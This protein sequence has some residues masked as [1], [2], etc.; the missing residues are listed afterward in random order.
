[1][2]I[3]GHA[4]NLVKTVAKR[5]CSHA[6][7]KHWIC[8]RVEVGEPRVAL[9]FDDGPDP[10]YTPVVL[11][12]LADCRVHATFFVLG[13]LV[14]RHGD[15]VERIVCEGH[16]IG[17]HG[18]DHTTQDLSGQI[19]RTERI[20][21]QYGI[22]TRY[23]RPPHGVLIPSLLLWTLRHGYTTALWSHD[24]RDAMRHEGKIDSGQSFDEVAPGD[25]VL[26]HDDNPICA[27]ELRGFLDVTRSKGMK[28]DTLARLLSS[29]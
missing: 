17:I 12:I 7:A 20:L 26:M 15:L 14:E 3:W 18:Y 8:W 29:P 24:S 21:R 23:F 16:D 6:P 10:E 11:D 4:R 5:Q 9:T 28:A 13:K 25:I 2:S 19:V 22:R 1:M 27:Q